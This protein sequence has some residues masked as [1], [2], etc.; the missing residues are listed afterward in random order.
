[1]RILIV[2]DEALLAMALSV[3]LQEAGHVVIGAAATA[4][5]AI[6]LADMAT[7]DL[8]LVDIRLRDGDSGTDVA[9]RLHRRGIPSLFISGQTDKARANRDS[10]LGCL[11][12]PCSP[13]TVL[14]SIEVAKA[15]IAGDAPA[16]L[17]RGLELF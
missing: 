8:A 13:A 4:P 14:A 1:M 17:P 10:A 6:T 12:K 15:I 16:A 7:P 9:R 11:G 2:E 5:S 3:S